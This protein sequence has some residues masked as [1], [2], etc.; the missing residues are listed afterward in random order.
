MLIGNNTGKRIASECDY[1]YVLKEK[2]SGIK[3]GKIF[4]FEAR[5]HGEEF[6][7]VFDALLAPMKS[8]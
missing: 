6:T 4:S 3:I 7:N 5:T 2:T 1:H 8:F